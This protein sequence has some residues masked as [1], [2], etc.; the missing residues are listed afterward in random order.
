MCASACVCICRLNADISINVDHVGVLSTDMPV[1]TTQFLL[2]S[3][4]KA[5]WTDG[6]GRMCLLAHVSRLARAEG[7]NSERGGARGILQSLNIDRLACQEERSVQ[8]YDSHRD[9]ESDTGSSLKM[10]KKKLAGKSHGA[11]CLV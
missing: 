7:R 3:S 5:T 2:P 11:Q 1:I 8:G 9:E 6:H 4:R 10:V